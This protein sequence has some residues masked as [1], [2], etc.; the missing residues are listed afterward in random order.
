MSQACA[1][2][3]RDLLAGVFGVQLTLL[4]GSLPLMRNLI[5]GMAIYSSWSIC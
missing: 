1:N 4:D 2:I 5:H 3:D